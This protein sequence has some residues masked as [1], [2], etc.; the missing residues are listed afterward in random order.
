[1]QYLE[2]VTGVRERHLQAGEMC[3]KCYKGV[4]LKRNGQFGKFYGCKRYPYCTFTSKTNQD[5]QNLAGKLLNRK[6][7]RRGKKHYKHYQQN[8]KTYG[9]NEK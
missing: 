5:L 6:K 2:E 1:M 9:P 8:N 4:L 3:P 7:P